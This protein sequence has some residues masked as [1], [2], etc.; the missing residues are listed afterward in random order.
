MSSML[1]VSP[2]TEDATID[3][4]ATWGSLLHAALPGCTALLVEWPHHHA[5]E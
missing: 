3:P 4:M 1:A 2:S 5:S